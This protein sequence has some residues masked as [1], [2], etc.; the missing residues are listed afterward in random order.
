MATW[1]QA[2]VEVSA[3]WAP[4]IAGRCA[5][6]DGHE[7]CAPGEQGMNW[8]LEAI[9]KYAVFTGRSRRSEYWYFV[10]FNALII[11]ALTVVDVAM[12]LYSIKGD[13]GLLS[14]IY[15]LA[16]FIPSFAVTVRRLHDTDR[17]GWWVLLAL[18]PIV[19]VIVLIVF[20]ATDGTPGSNRFGENPKQA[21][22]VA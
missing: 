11:I 15:S 18:I 6:R 14:G 1:R 9:R 20:F 10:L 8:Y 7:N 13:V 21:E 12:G 3:E 22:A 17:S 4:E 19:G 5:A 2:A 16:I